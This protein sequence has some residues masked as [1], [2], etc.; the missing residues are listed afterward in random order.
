M[1]FQSQEDPI[2]GPFIKVWRGKNHLGHSSSGYLFLGILLYGGRYL[3]N[4]TLNVMK[5]DKDIK[6]G[7]RD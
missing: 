6:R 2:K 3:I 5:T 1:T 7:L 4:D